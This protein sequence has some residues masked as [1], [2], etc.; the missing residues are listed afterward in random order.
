MSQQVQ[1][2]G[3]KP[4]HKIARTDYINEKVTRPWFYFHEPM[5][6][7]F[8]DHVGWV[9]L[10]GS[11]SLTPGCNGVEADSKGNVDYTS[12]L[13]V[14]ARK[15]HIAI[16]PYDRGLD[17]Q[18]RP[19][20]REYDCIEGS[21]GK[22]KIGLHHRSMFERAVRIGMRTLWTRDDDAW[23]AFLR[24]LVDRGLVESMLPEVLILQMELQ[25]HRI[26]RAAKQTS[27]FFRTKMEMEIAR[28][29][30]MR[31]AY[32]E[33]FPSDAPAPEPVTVQARTPA[34]APVPVPV[35]GRKPKATTRKPRK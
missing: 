27:A 2:R 8:D 28:M 9:P 22:G 17:E 29:S 20:Y 13:T 31:S 34:A 15:G 4:E 35:K 1:V 19:Y 26:D 25:Q 24:H 12:P 10:L 11:I 14:L 30:K 23:Y 32:A 16:L 18:Y 7:M 3:R 5:G 21:G 33:Q 6:W